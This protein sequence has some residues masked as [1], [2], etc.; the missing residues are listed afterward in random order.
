MQVLV[1]C[2]LSCKV[3]GAMPY[4]AVAGTFSPDLR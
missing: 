1:F 4:R 2:P 3:S